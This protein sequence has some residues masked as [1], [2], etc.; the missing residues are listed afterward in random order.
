MGAL[1]SSD[2]VLQTGGGQCPHCAVGVTN[3]LVEIHEYNLD[4]VPGFGSRRCWFATH[5]DAG[6]FR[7]HECCPNLRTVAC[8][9]VGTTMTVGDRRVNR[10]RPATVS[11]IALRTQAQRDR[12]E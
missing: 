1:I 3:V 7:M 10:A 12:R 9:S 8:R 11:S 4:T 5:P 6:G 2:H